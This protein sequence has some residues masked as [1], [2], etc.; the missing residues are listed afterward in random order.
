M[1]DLYFSGMEMGW[2]ELVKI[3]ESGVEPK[4]RCIMMSYLYI[5][6]SP[7]Q[8]AEQLK[9]FRKKYGGKVMVDSGAY[10]FLNNY[11]LAKGMNV[12]GVSRSES[13]DAKALLGKEDE[14]IH[15]YM[16]WLEANRDSYD[17]AVELDIRVIVGKEQLTKWREEF[18]ARKI[19]IVVVT[20]TSAGDDIN[21]VK[22][23]A[24]KGV[25][26]FG[27]GELVKDRANELA[28]LR[29]VADLGL[30]MH[31]FQFTPLD[32]FK[33]KQWI[34]SV[35]STTWL[36]AEKSG[37]LMILRGKQP[38]MYNI[39]DEPLRAK[40]CLDSPVIRLFGKEQ[41]TEEVMVKH[42]YYWLNFWNL[43][44]MQKWADL[45]NEVKGYETAIAQLNESGGVPSWMLEK[46]RMGRSKAIYAKSRF[47]AVKH[48]T[49]ARAVHKNAM[50]CNKC[51]IKDSCMMFQPN[52][53]CYFIP[54]WRKAGGA[55][56]DKE[57]I[58]RM[59]QDNVADLY[60]RLQRG[61]LVEE[62]SGGVTDR[63]VTGLQDQLNKSL[64]LLH[65]VQS[66]ST[67][68]MQIA[69]AA[70]KD[71]AMVA[72]KTGLDQALTE[73]RAEYGDALMKRIEKRTEEQ[74]E[75]VQA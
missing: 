69:I 62:V 32:L 57:Q 3:C 71:G 2:D 63:A 34:T 48:A 51:V 23:W 49:Y 52:E 1:T 73:M 17:Y 40:Q 38:E 43:I 25:Q 44:E 31:V 72:M 41:A 30:K 39:R 54:F 7:E 56:R 10:S 29:N 50:E 12:K 4:P 68:G 47:N 58:V 8:R 67:G 42:K 22:D 13:S 15:R 6:K 59:L 65:R 16:D 70:G 27:I 36:F 61:L 35:D 33:Y 75:E 37:D 9:T 74:K 45:N 21:M 24:A 14:Y 60:V 28:F 26:Y 46:D 64:E 18:L 19:P 53:L 20:H 11:Y 55:T 66:G 5:R